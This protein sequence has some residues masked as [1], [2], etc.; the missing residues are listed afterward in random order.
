MPKQVHGKPLTD[1]EHRQWKDI[2]ATT[3]KPAIA[4]AA[5]LKSMKKRKGPPKKV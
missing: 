1:K 5:V 4:M 2:M 3:G